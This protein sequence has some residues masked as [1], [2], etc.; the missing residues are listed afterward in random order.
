MIVPVRMALEVG[1]VGIHKKKRPHSLSDHH[2][3]S[4]PLTP[5]PGIDNQQ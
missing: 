2:H 3:H 5:G 4:L 1:A